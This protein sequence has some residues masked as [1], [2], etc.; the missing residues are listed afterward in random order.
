MR[1]A[2]RLIITLIGVTFWC[3]AATTVAYAHPQGSRHGALI[4][5]RFRAGF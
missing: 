4:S 1:H 3:V 5:A 2:R